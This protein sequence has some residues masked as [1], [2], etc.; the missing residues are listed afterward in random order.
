M[1][2]DPTLFTSSQMGQALVHNYLG[3]HSMHPTFK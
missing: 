2:T 1:Q 3:H